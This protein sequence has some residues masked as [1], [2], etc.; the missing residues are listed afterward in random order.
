MK[1]IALGQYYPVTSP[2]HRLDARMKVILAVLY[3]YFTT[4]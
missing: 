4:K 1:S 2:M 3:I